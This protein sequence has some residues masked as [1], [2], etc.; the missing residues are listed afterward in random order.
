MYNSLAQEIY[1]RISRELLNP[2]WLEESKLEQK[3]IKTGIENSAFIESINSIVKNNDYTCKSVLSMCQDMLNEL[4]GSFVPED[5]LFYIYEFTLS[6]SFP[7]AVT[8]NLSENVNTACSLYLR[9]LRIVSLYQLYS[10]DETWQSKY[11]MKFLTPH[12]IDELEYPGEYKLFTQAFYNDYIYEMMKLSYDAL[13]L[14]TLDHV[15]GVHYLSL[16]IGRQLKKSGLPVDLGRVSG[17]AAGHDIGKYGCKGYELKRVPYLHYYYSDQWFKKYGITYI[18]HIAL[19]HSTWDLELENLPLESLI[20][21]YSDFRVKSIKLEDGKHSMNIYTLDDSFDVVLKKLDNVDNAKE[22][23]YKRVYAKLKD[24]EDYMINLGIDLNP[25]NGISTGPLFKSNL[26]YSLMQGYEVINHIKFLSINHNINLMFQLRDEFSL[27]NILQ[28]ARSQKDW[29]ILREYIRVFEEYSTYLTQKQKLQ[30]IKFLYDQLIHPEDDIRRH[31]AELIGTLIAIY[32]EDYRKEI[33]ENESSNNPGITSIELL[34]EYLRLF[35]IPGHKIIPAHRAWI[36]YSTSIMVSSVFSHCRNTSCNQ[37]KKIL[38]KYYKEEFFKNKETMVYLLKIAECITVSDNEDYLYPIFDFVIHMLKKQNIVLRLSALETADS[39]IP[40]LT[41]NCNFIVTLKSFFESKLSRSTFPAE[42]YLKLRVARSLCLKQEYIDKFSYYCKLDR[43]KI[44]DI[45]LN[46]LKTATDW[47]VKKINI[48]VLLEHTLE[49]PMA[50]GLHAAMHFCNLLKVSAIE[51]VRSH[52]GESILKIM[53]CLPIEQRNDV[54][55]ELI[56]ALEIE[57]YQFTEY[58]PHYLGQMVLWLQPVELDEL[59]DDLIEKIKQSRPQIKSLLLKTIGISIANFPEYNI[60]FPESKGLFEKR[61]FKMLG[62]LLNGLGDY[63]PLVRQVAFSVLGKEIFGTKHLNLEQKIHLFKLT[64]KKILTLITDNK[65]EVL[66]LLANSAGLN[67]IY[68]FISDYSFFKGTIDLNSPKRIAFFPGTFD[69]F[70]LSHK[71]IVRAIRDM[72]FEVYLAVDEFSWSKRTLPNLVRRK[73]INMSIADEPDVYL[74]PESIPVNISN[75]EDLKILK[76]SFLNSEVYIAIGSDVIVNASSYSVNKTP[77]SVYSFPHIIIEREAFYNS[78]NRGKFDN[79][80]SRIDAAV[81][82]LS[83]PRKLMNISSSQIRNYIDENRDISSL[84]D[85][86]VQKYIYEYD[87]YR[88]EPQ[89]K[90]LLQSSLSMDIQEIKSFDTALIKELASFIDKKQDIVEK[91]LI[92]FSKKQSARFII[93]RDTN[94]HNKLL[95][96]SAFHWLRSSNLY[97]ELGDKKISEYIRDNTIGRI[98][99][100]DG[101]FIDSSQKNK[102]IEQIILTE[103][104]ALCLSKDY[105]FAIFKN[106]A[107]N[108]SSQGLYEI[109]RLQGFELLPVGSNA[110]PIFITNMTNPCAFNLD[111]DTIIKEPF[112]GN[113]RVRQVISLSRKRLQE[114]LTKLYPGQLVLSFDMNV[115]HESM[116]KKICYENGVPANIVS[117]RRLGPA[118]CVP[119]GNILDR[120]IVPNTVTKALHTEKHFTPDMKSFGIGAFPHYS[121]LEIQAK[122]IHSFNKPVIL[123]DDLLHKGHRLKAIGPVFEKEKVKIQKIIVGILTGQGKEIMDMEGKE[124]DG[125]YFLPRLRAWFNENSLYPFM[126]GDALWRGAYPERNLLPSI[127]LILPYTSPRF[128]TGA[129]KISIYNLS[130]VAIE[131]AIEIL[132]TIEGEYHILNERRLTL[133]SLGDVFISPRCPDHGKDIDYDLSLSPSHFLKNDLELLNRLEHT[134][135]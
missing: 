102:P 41:D 106:M 70:T 31:C 21:I 58:I 3:F 124:V 67:H 65:N 36:G 14:S 51:N 82:E 53:P 105:E 132:S 92:E 45:F 60:R 84:V 117:P 113:P 47:V 25:N 134:I 54:A 27:D 16:F 44:P 69:P 11:P 78:E 98:V 119:Y 34:D 81:L 116:I 129:S 111:V 128:I 73:I 46:N 121:D 61:L 10:N 109:L 118:M 43:K 85:P 8:I 87:F 110:N 72:G 29:K 40:S 59:I 23:R 1:D 39:F 91:K 103:T 32:D 24:F 89:V 94:D 133:S 33:P 125:V 49:D 42:N 48:A 19:N 112:R 114:A 7:E 74:Y 96:F 97:R 13:G 88:R 6:K 5:F 93:V 56:R 77:G 120:H 95:A 15:C 22:K 99:L 17:A 12:E 101:I 57:G 2:K 79:V 37:Y 130:K 86:L 4:S 80:K 127:N 26:N 55:V 63:N 64:A 107:D 35:L 28:A 9:V 38:L 20:L 131:N 122:V 83:I 100:I 115:Q 90:T 30:T 75:S 76:Q 68:R 71:E 62:I 104:L 18:R 52:A 126:G 123:V 108:Y 135:R 50:H 66:Q